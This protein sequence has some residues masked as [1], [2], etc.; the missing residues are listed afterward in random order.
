MLPVTSYYSVS[1]LI[2]ATPDD[3]AQGKVWSGGGGGGRGDDDGCSN[4]RSEGR[5]HG[6]TQPSAYEVNRR[7]VCL[8]GTIA[9]S[10]LMNVTALPGIPCECEQNSRASLHG[11]RHNGNSSLTCCKLI[12][13][14]NCYVGPLFLGA[15]SYIR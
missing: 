1:S 11:I 14:A 7:L 9:Q 5:G 13:D 4:P 8:T 3:V 12:R 2:T 6:C 15:V 10:E